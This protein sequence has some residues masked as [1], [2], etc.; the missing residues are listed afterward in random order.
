MNVRQN[1]DA[2]VKIKDQNMILAQKFLD[3][4]WHTWK[5][6]LGKESTIG[7]HSP[8]NKKK[9]WTHVL[10]SAIPCGEESNVGV[11]VEVL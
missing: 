8:G 11:E 4:I 7:L 1:N 6:Q 3:L 2:N 10:M 9:V 5:E